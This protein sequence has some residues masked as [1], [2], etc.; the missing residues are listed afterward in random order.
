MTANVMSGDRERCIAAGMDGYISKPISASKV[1]EEI[2]RVLGGL[3]VPVA[4][5]PRDSVEPVFDY[6]QML[7][8]CDGDLAFVPSLLQ[9]FAEDAPRLL[10]EIRA[11]LQADDLLRCGIAAHSMRGSALSLAA[12]A[13]IQ[14]CQVLERACKQGDLV[15]A[16][17]ALPLVDTALQQLLA[18]IQPYQTAAAG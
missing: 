6:A 12:S 2:A 1:Q 3:P 18:A 4:P 13:L 7:R 9:A 8:N 5:A 10:E 15:T 11:A 14:H 16:H 17:A